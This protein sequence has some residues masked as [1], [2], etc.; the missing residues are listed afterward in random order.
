[1]RRPGT[2]H[3]FTLLEVM[4]ALA[5]LAAALVLVGHGIAQNVRQA[6]HARMTRTAALL[7]RQ[8][9]ADIEYDLYK[10]GFSDFAEEDGSN[11]S[12]Q[13]FPGF[14]WTMRAEKI[15][16]PANLGQAAAEASQKLS[17]ATKDLAQSA[18]ANTRALAQAT[19]GS[20]MSTLLASFGGII[21]QVR[22]AMEDSVRRV[23]LRVLWSEGRRDSRGTPLDDHLEVA[24]YFVDTTRMAIG[25]GAGV[26]LPGG[27]GLPGGLGGASGFGGAGGFGGR[28]GADGSRGG[29]G[30]TG[31][32]GGSGSGTGG[33]G[34]VIK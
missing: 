29:T 26:A 12:E 3:G 33:G 13:G 10:N 4:V 7:V 5:I 32:R 24:A 16:L 11:F 9:M 8:K 17:E 1:M 31:G 21:D 18:T 19:D 14:R 20:M 23:T 2:S 27:A 22:L 6:Q 28:G 34:K 30:G 15:E 25:T